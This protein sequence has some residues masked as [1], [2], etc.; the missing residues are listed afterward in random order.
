MS[1]CS[2]SVYTPPDE[3]ELAQKII[4]LLEDK[5]L[6]HQLGTK[7]RVRVIEQFSSERV[8]NLTEGFYKQA[9]EDCK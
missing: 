5:N 7:A 2:I 6:R 8:M 3:N 9:L 4:R 1:G